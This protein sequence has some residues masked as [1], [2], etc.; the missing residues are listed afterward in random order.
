MIIAAYCHNIFCSSAGNKRN[1]L[2]SHLTGNSL[3]LLSP[4]LHRF[5]KISLNNGKA[6]Y[7]SLLFSST[8]KFMNKC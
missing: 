6:L 3:V 1:L 4:P 5:A 7:D 2:V 8:A